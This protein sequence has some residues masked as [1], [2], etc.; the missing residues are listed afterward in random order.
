MEYL[1]LVLDFSVPLECNVTMATFISGLL[2]DFEHVKGTSSTPAAASLFDSTA[3]SPPLPEAQRRL[4]HSAAA[5]LLYIGNRARPDF[6]LVSSA[7]TAKATCATEMDL[8]RL[9]QAIRHLRG[10][11]DKPLRL[12]CN[13]PIQVRAFID[14]SFASNGLK[15]QSGSCMMLGDGAVF[16]SST[17]QSL[18]VKSSTEA[19]LV[20]VSDS[21]G[22]FIH[23]RHVI[24]DQ[25]YE[26][27]PIV[28][29][30]DNTATMAM[31]QNG[32]SHSAR[33]RHIAIRHFWVSERITT[34]EV[35]LAWC[36]S[37]QM[38]GD[39]M[40]KPVGVTDFCIQCPRLLGHTSSRVTS[41]LED[42]ASQKAGNPK[43][44]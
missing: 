32:G 22:S 2:A 25:G 16:A 35:A 7:L 31:L 44:G 27:G 20:A 13:Y 26:V 14:A 5:S 11:K 9:H 24:C 17:K 4:F 36:E 29:Y 3:A 38:S 6:S 43:N 42:R 18:V 8:K 12:T 30:Q 23:A 15:S 41:S 21:A 34:G 1:G 37:G 39:M 10:S 19:E 28:L 40:T 33:T